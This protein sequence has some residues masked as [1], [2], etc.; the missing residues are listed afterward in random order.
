MRVLSVSARKAVEGVTDTSV[1]LRWPYHRHFA[2]ASSDAVA[3]YSHVFSTA[4]RKI[5]DEAGLVLISNRRTRLC[6]RQAF[7][8]VVRQ[9]TQTL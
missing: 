1:R 7:L 4:A 8:L 2:A 9:V 6:G 3:G 5:E